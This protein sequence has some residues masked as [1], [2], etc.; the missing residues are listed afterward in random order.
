MIWKRRLPIVPASFF[1]MVLGLVGLGGA[2]RAAMAAWGLPAFIG[3]AITVVGVFVWAAL[4]LLTLAKW[5]QARQA[6]LAEVNHPVQG[7]FVALVG[8]TTSLVSLAVLPYGRPAALLLFTAG[9]L[10]T[11]A[12]A[13]WRMGD[14]WRRDDE[15]PVTPVLYLPTVGGGFVTA[16][17]AAAFDFRE[18]GYL[19]F[20]FGL[21]SWLAIESLVLR[22]LLARPGLP[23]AMRPTL[24]IQLAPPAVGGVA[25]LSLFGEAAA[26][27][28][29]TMVGYALFQVLLALRLLGWFRAQPFVP[30][31]WSFSFGA[32]A[33]GSLGIHLA[34]VNT[35]ALSAALA[36]ILFVAANLAVAALVIATVRLAAEG[37]LLQSA[38]GPIPR[39]ATPSAVRV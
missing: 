6:A 22:V 18:L 10:T 26:P 37:R 27:F 15:V 1:G 4:V 5:M 33:L 17:A 34:K 39:A 20:G 13:V 21:F 12:F 2:W 31:Y 36:P 24:G 3:E 25:A 28:V 16:T 11:V 9:A 35:G 23:V 38:S 19:A 29:L 32:T 14:I 8:V 7:G 30:G